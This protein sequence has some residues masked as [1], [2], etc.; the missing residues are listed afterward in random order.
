M[1]SVWHLNLVIKSV[2][3]VSLSVV[4]TDR[5]KRSLEK[6]AF[7][8]ENQKLCALKSAHHVPPLF[9]MTFVTNQ[10]SRSI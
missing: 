8:Q 6:F 2:R 3:F 5:W 1:L 10:R 4:G 7:F 9:V